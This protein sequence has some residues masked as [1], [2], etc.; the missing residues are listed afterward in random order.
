MFSDSLVVWLFVASSEVAVE[1]YTLAIATGHTVIRE[2][3][4]RIKHLA[5]RAAAVSHA[6]QR[7]CG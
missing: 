2:V 5:S 6:E 1:S 4:G 3:E 7:D